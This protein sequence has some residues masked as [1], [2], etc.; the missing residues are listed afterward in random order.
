LAKE[1]Y[2]EHGYSYL[3]DDPDLIFWDYSYNIHKNNNG[4]HFDLRLYCPSGSTV[5][6]SWSAQTSL[7][8]KAHPIKLRRTKD[9]DRSWLT[10]EG[11]Y[12]SNAGHKNTI[13]IIERDMAELINLEKDG[14][15]FKTTL[16][17]FKIKHVKG[18]QY[19]FVP[20]SGLIK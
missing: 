10:F 13:K 1:K 17:K 19:M 11:E 2:Y 14:F 4:T 3:T 8:D 18:K 7:L 5:V 20:L 16:R 15:T 6:Y 12:I 9:H